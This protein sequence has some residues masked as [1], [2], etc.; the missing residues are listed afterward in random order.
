MMLMMLVMLIMLM[1]LDVDAMHE[2]ML[3]WSMCAC[4]SANAD[5]CAVRM[6]AE[7]REAESASRKCDKLAARPSLRNRGSGRT[8]A[9]AARASWLLVWGARDPR[10]FGTSESE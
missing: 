9:L 3:C 1:M 7:E 4:A 6:D 10:P 8:S 2:E 5:A